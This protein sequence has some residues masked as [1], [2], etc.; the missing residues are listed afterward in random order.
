MPQRPRYARQEGRRG[1]ARRRWGVVLAGGDGVRLRRLTRF[2]YGDD[3]PKQF[4]QFLGDATLLEQA[5]RRAERNIPA[6]QILFALTRAHE[7]YYLQDLGGKPSQ[8]IVQ[9]CNRG[10][11]PA[12]LYTLL[13]ITRLDR[14]AFVAVLPSDHYYSPED[15]FAATLESAFETVRAQ[16]T[17]IVILGAQPKGP[18]I[19]FGWIS[20]AGTSRTSHAEVFH[21]ADFHEKPPLDVASR[22]LRSGALWNT[23]VMVGHVQAFL[24]MACKSVPRLLEVFRSEPAPHVSSGETRI[25]EEVYDRI[26]AVDFSRQVLSP[27]ATGLLTLSLGGVE[28]NDLGDPDR[29][30]STLLRSGIELPSWALRWRAA[31]RE[32]STATQPMTTVA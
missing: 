12:I 5:R 6:D 24:G 27:A 31:N 28:W 11:A 32:P 21:V 19:E 26:A 4:C 22:L 9:P 7:N 3:R 25:A 10:T 20:L 30:L 23:F 14:D 8:R 2:I 1:D 18:E 15:S 13:H 29:V 17:S 16:P